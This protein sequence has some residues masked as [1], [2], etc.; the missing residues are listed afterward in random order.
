MS[1][2]KKDLY[3]VANF[4]ELFLKGKNIGFFEGKL[5]SNLT[6]KLVEFK[7]EITFEKK[8]GGSFYIKLSKKLK[9]SQILKIEEI[10]KNTP[11]II[12]FYQ[13]YICETDLEQISKVAVFLAQQEIRGQGPLIETFGI[14]AE[15]VE[16]EAKYSSLELGKEVG[17]AVWNEIKKDVD[18]NHPDLQINIKESKNQ[19]IIFL[20]KQSAV[21]GMPI[22]SSGKALVFLSGGIDSPVAAFYAMKRGLE[23]TVVHFHAV[24][25]TS[26]Q[27]IE[28]V[29]ELVEKLKK[30]QPNIKLI[31]IP[32]IELQMAIKK[33][34]N[35]KLRLVLLRRA[36]LKIGEKVAEREFGTKKFVFI[37][38][39][40]LAQVASQTLENLSVI[41]SA[42]SKLILRPLIG[43]DKSEII[44]KAREIGTYEISIQPHDDAC[45]L[46]VPKSP[47][48]KANLE[49][50]EK[51]E[52]KYN[53]DKIIENIL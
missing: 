27:S 28:K 11:G 30:Y 13:A 43:F 38:G 49:T 40:S 6:E 12:N 42:T 37:S 2:F 51:E 23:I 1:D 41:N 25:K 19:T 53:L 32:I 50:T 20:K 52:Q 33:N 47:E 24:P 7:D 16:K 15:R 17:S 21:G 36:M 26:P 29:K 48:T 14:K 31:L 9:I 18:L 45:S 46:F 5:F 4:G 10:I 44:E 39:D 8:R 22:G 3:I 35:E 34:C